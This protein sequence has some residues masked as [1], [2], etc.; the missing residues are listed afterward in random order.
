MKE[1][2]VRK[3]KL[4]EVGEIFI[5]KEIDMPCFASRSTA[6]PDAG[7]G[8][9]AFEFGSARVKLSVTKDP[10]AR[11]RL[12][13]SPGGFSILLDGEPLVEGVRVLPLVAHA[14]N[15]AFLNIGQE[16]IM[17]CAFCAMPG[18]GAEHAEP[19]SAERALKIISINASHPSFSAVAITSG[20]PESVSATN[21]S[22][23]DMVRTIRAH[24]PAIPIG[25]EAYIEDPDDILR[26]REAGATEIK[27]NIETWPSELFR[28]L[29][30][31]RDRVRTLAALEKA[32]EVF[33]RGHVTCNLIVGMGET[34]RDV[35][36]GLKALAELGVVPNVRA[37]RIGPLNRAKLEKA[38]GAVPGKVTAERLLAL[39]E[40]HRKI[41]EKNGLDTGTFETMCFSCRCCDIV[42]MADL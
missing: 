2:T 7:S 38:L 10:E 27:I 40:Q 11:V 29:C 22:I 1:D 20:I 31:G 19:L 28:K 14:P 42:P 4:L 16:C 35:A 9:H 34:D 33:G 15:Q 32:V 21:D 41:L 24:Y 6:G 25:A 12:E 39:G 3:A 30:P 36:D 17:G 5:P 8:A 37:I 13:Q 26:F 23:I 18:P